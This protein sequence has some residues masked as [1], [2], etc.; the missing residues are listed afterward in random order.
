MRKP[1]YLAAVLCLVGAL[2]VA[3]SLLAQEPAPPEEPVAEG[4]STEPDAIEGADIVIGLEA[5]EATSTSPP[6]VPLP[7]AIQLKDLPNDDGTGLLL[8]FEAPRG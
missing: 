1:I 4:A 8:E 3:P 5:T 2:A 6:A 7:S